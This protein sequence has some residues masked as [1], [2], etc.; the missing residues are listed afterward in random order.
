MNELNSQ[1][2]KLYYDRIDRL[3]T[4][5]CGES[6]KHYPR[7]I[8]GLFSLAVAE[9]A[10]GGKLALWKHITEMERL[11]HADFTEEEKQELEQIDQ[12]MDERKKRE[13]EEL[14][15][16][17]TPDLVTN[18]LYQDV[19]DLATW[20]LGSADE[21]EEKFD[22]TFEHTMMYRYE[23]AVV[24]VEGQQKVVWEKVK[25]LNDSEEIITGY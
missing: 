8:V 1:Q 6:V 23:K 13:Q 9:I 20:L 3:K 21:S 22:K 18:P 10:M 11:I 17:F 7:Y 16:D 2:L 15:Q 14:L 5:L 4:A 25:S 12:D 19:M 24:Q